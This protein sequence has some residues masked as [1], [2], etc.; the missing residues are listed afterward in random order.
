MKQHHLNHTKGTNIN[1]TLSWLLVIITGLLFLTSCKKDSVTN[2]VQTE[3]SLL[4]LNFNDTTIAKNLVDSGVAV[5]KRKSTQTPYIL[6]F[7]NEGP[8]LQ[9][10]IGGMH[11]GEYTADIYLYCRVANNAS[12]REYYR[13]ITFMQGSNNG[14]VN[15]GA[16]N[17]TL[18]D[19][20]RP[21]AILSYNKEI[22]F[23]VSLD[24]SDP[25]FRI[26]V[27]DAG[28]WK[29][30]E[31]QR[32]ANNK[33]AGTGTELVAG[34]VWKCETSCFNTGNIM[35]NNTAFIPLTEKLAGKAWDFGEIEILAESKSGIK[36][37]D[38]FKYDR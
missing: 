25:Y 1:Q 30:V 8:G 21:R 27:A 14:V 37:E 17:G 5:L 38:Y 28:Y 7:Q 2:P 20:W 18:K 26:Q 35:E 9:I 4:I 13:Q 12:R 3:D 10:A 36:T 11:A 16:A 19:S 22:D 34:H 23:Y 33:I 15:V 6:R 31:V 32:Y 24:N 29:K